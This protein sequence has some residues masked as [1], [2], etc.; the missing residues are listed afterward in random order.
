MEDLSTPLVLGF[1]AGFFL[2]AVLTLTAFVK[3]S[4]V[5]MV[6]RQGLGLQQVPSNIIVLALALFLALFVSA[7]VFSASLS[8]VLDSGVELNTA[9]NL[10]DLWNVA[11]A[12]F[13]TF[14]GRNID[15]E[16]AQFFIASAEELW[17]GSG[18]SATVEDFVIQVPAFMISELTEAFRIGFLLYLP[19]I[20]I[21][22]A[23]TGILMALGMQM[24][25]PNI[26]AVPFKL[27]L[28]VFVD[29][30][31]RLAEGLLVGYG[32]A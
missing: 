13:Q 15:P 17:V 10:F 18:L 2:L 27:L 25:Q 8:A 12:P 16:H 3:I 14:M 32:G 28:F 20:A 30:W 11:I 19:F 24:V 26:I 21:D 9:Q 22:L 31:A 29:G 1:V 4:V 5:L 23:I 6:I 7:P